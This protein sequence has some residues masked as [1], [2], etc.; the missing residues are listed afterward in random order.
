M[1]SN[2]LFGNFGIWANDVIVSKSSFLYLCFGLDDVPVSDLRIQDVWLDSEGIVAADAH[3]IILFGCGFEHDDCPL[4]DDIVVPKNYL[5]VFVFFLA[6]YGTGRIDNTSLSEDY[7]AY[8][9][10]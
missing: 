4:F 8:D 2:K 9:L 1:I 5:E 6:N 7:V 3:D 10:V